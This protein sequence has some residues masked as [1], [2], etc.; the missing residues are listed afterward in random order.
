MKPLLIRA[1]G[2]PAIGSGHLMRCLALAEAWKEN[3]GTVIF[4]IATPSPSPSLEERLSPEAAEVLHI[5]VT[6]GSPEDAQ[7]TARL[8]QERGC[9][10]VVVDG[11]QFGADY[12]RHLRDAGFS[13]LA[14][15]D[16]GHAAHYYAD[17]VLNQNSYADRSFYPHH[18]PSTRFL[19]GPEYVLLRREFRDRAG[20]ARTIPAIARKVLVTFGGADPENATLAAIRALAQVPVDGLEVIIVVGGMNPHYDALRESVKDRPGFSIRKDVRDMPGLMAWAD[21]AISAGGSTCWELA[22]M[23]LPALVHPLAANQEPVVRSL[24]SRGVADELTA[25]DL[26]GGEGAVQKITEFL[27]SHWRRCRFSRQSKDLVDGEG[28][29]RV[30]MCI[31]QDRIRLRPVRASDRDLV[32]T[33]INDPEVRARSFHT[34]AIAPDEHRAWF[35]RVIGDT[36]I[37]YLIAVDADD[38]PVGQA[39]FSLE[40]GRA[41]ISVLIEPGS[42]SK[43][44]GSLLIAAAT[45]RLFRTTAVPEVHAYIK[46]GNESSLKAFTR[47]GYTRAGTV[48]VEGQ[49]AYHLIVKRGG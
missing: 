49:D 15:D 38:R 46:T 39:R 16:Y 31:S 30:A 25:G 45:D 5:A 40:P 4:V 6:P 1:D 32:F 3:G 11:Y 36:T 41:V 8:A 23:G 19:L 35:A 37:R 24:V 44:L 2:G 47:A 22:F 26:F 21:I 34:G 13:L 20:Y 7:K 27:T 42:R 43:G 10:W 48:T 14:I 29:S 12:Q 9:V 33:W 28:A 18:E 17:I